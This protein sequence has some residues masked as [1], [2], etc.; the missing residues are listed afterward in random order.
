MSPSQHTRA[1]SRQ[2]R[3]GSRRTCTGEDT[4]N[5]SRARRNTSRMGPRSLSRMSKQ[6][7][8]QLVRERDAQLCLVSEEHTHNMNAT[9]LATT[10]LINT[11]TS[12]QTHQNL[13]Q[14]H[15]GMLETNRGLMLQQMALLRCT[16]A[17]M[18]P[19]VETA[20]PSTSPLNS[21]GC[22]S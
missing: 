4:R 9:R 14:Q 6:E 18:T 17:S 3:N 12:L 19:P 5:S 2:T 8:V 10:Q 16:P 1:R 15:I 22:T 7:L 21:T 13:L 20:E 11:I